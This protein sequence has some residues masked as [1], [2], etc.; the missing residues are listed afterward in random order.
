MGEETRRARLK[1]QAY[2]TVSDSNHNNPCSLQPLHR[3]AGLKNNSDEEKG[4]HR[5]SQ[6][7][8]LWEATPDLRPKSQK[9]PAVQKDLAQ[10]ILLVAET[11]SRTLMLWP[12]STGV[13]QKRMAE[14]SAAQLHSA[15]QR[16]LGF[17][18]YHN[19]KPLE[20]F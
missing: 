13:K 19:W 18:F 9:E 8:L 4:T 10:S 2:E 20:T 17:S 11:T 1:T 16:Q 5:G 7:K 14:A 3:A 6:A 15:E 12:G